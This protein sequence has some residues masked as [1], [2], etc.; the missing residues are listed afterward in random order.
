[1]NKLA[2]GFFI[3]P[4]IWK[5]LDSVMEEKCTSVRVK[6]QD[7]SSYFSAVKCHTN[8]N[9]Q[10]TKCNRTNVNFSISLQSCYFWWIFF[11]YT[12]NQCTV[13]SN[14][15]L[16]CTLEPS[17]HFRLIFSFYESLSSGGGWGSFFIYLTFINPATV[18]RSLVINNEGYLISDYK[19]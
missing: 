15:H 8:A 16:L 2:I 17:L 7:K 11:W 10:I 3:Q 9:C 14:H 6:V 18:P 19:P 5:V 1:M 13:F 12:R 4:F